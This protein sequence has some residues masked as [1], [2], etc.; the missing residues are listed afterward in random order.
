[1]KPIHI[2]VQEAVFFHDECDIGIFKNT[3]DKQLH[4]LKE[5]RDTIVLTMS[6]IS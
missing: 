5:T 2:S 3:L 4:S 1:M 6:N